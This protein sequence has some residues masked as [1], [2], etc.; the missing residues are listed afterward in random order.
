MDVW[1]KYVL[2]DDLI[3]IF[4]LEFCMLL[5]RA[6]I[7]YPANLVRRCCPR[8]TLSREFAMAL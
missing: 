1:I 7:I 3:H 2:L 4:S 8:P 5:E 6:L